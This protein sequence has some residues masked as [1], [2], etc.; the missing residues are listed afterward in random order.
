MKRRYTLNAEPGRYDLTGSSAGG[1]L[2]A[3][4]TGR[5]IDAEGRYSEAKD[6]VEG[7]EASQA[8]VANLEEELLRSLVP[9]ESLAFE[10]PL[11]RGRFLSDPPGSFHDFGPP[12]SDRA[13]RGR[14][15]A[16]GVPALY[17]CS[18]VGGVVREL[19]SPPANCRLWVQRFRIQPDV[20]MADA[21]QLAVDSFAAAVFWLIESGRDFGAAPRLGQRI[22]EVI[23]TEF[24]GLIVPGVRGEPNQ[25]YWNAVILRPGDR[26]RQF[27]DQSAGPEEAS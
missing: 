6:W 18:S 1:A 11:F 7:Y 27:V 14:Y 5:W 22:G 13:T 17:L 2:G 26:W 20:R 24:D 23:A 9:A 25:L 8:I 3:A 19:G 16:K 15:S 10:L 12:P 21:R 4:Y